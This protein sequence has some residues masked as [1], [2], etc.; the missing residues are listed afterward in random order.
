MSLTSFNHTHSAL[1]TL[2]IES[3]HGLR[4]AK[5]AGD[6]AVDGGCEDVGGHLCFVTANFPDASSRLLG[7]PS[8]I[9]YRGAAVEPPLPPCYYIPSYSMLP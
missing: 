3:N 1:N 7:S 5:L 4:S 2:M 9:I 8:R 6:V